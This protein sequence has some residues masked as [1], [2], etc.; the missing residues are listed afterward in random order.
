MPLALLALIAFAF[1]REAGLFVVRNADPLAATLPGDRLLVSRWPYRRHPPGRGDLVVTT[2]PLA[3][4]RVVAEPGEAF[5]VTER[6]WALNGRALLRWRVADA[7]PACSA[8]DCRQRWAALFPDGR[9]LVLPRLAVGRFR[10]GA[11]RLLLLD[12]A[13]TLAL[14]PVADVA[15]QAGPVVFSLDPSQAAGGRAWFGAVRWARTGLPLGGA[16]LIG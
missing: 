14:H 9:V 15:G 1:H 4:G 7:G 11:D 2:N 8:A 16:R 6:G 5:D 13:G 10:I 12:G 3:L